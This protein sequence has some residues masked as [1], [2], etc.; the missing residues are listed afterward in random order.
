[1]LQFRHSGDAQQRKENYPSPVKTTFRNSKGGSAVI[2]GALKILA[3][4]RLSDYFL[5]KCSLIFGDDSTTKAR[6][7]DILT[8]K[9]RMTELTNLQKW[10]TQNT[11]KNWAHVNI[12]RTQLEVLDDISQLGKGEEGSGAV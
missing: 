9:V 3:L 7:C 12:F 1:M 5:G 6:R 11:P 4:P 8:T 2:I 10:P